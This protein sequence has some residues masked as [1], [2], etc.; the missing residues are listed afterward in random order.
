MIYLLSVF[1]AFWSRLAEIGDHVHDKP[2][3]LSYHVLIDS[4]PF[5]FC[6]GR[7]G[8]HVGDF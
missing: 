7:L 4:S 2:V 3:S 8:H 1:Y 5:I 6:S